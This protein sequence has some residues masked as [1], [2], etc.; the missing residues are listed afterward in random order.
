MR[1]SKK[2][3][4]DR[5]LG[6][7][8]PPED[9][10]TEIDDPVQYHG[11]MVSKSVVPQLK[12]LEER[13]VSSS[14]R[15]YA[16]GQSERSLRRK[17]HKVR[18][19]K[20]ELQAKQEALFAMQRQHAAA[21]SFQPQLLYPALFARLPVWQPTAQPVLPP[22]AVPASFQQ[23]GLPMGATIGSVPGSPVSVV[24]LA[25]AVSMP[26]ASVHPALGMLSYQAR[27]ALSLLA[28]AANKPNN[29]QQ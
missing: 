23:P 26:P 15:P 9:D 2:F 20:Q 8:V 24:S 28:I 29:A 25:P 22:T 12:L 14:V 5:A 13:F 7:M 1:I 19:M 11:S 21:L 4:G 16:R 10:S 17:R 6:R 3:T 18:K 27:S